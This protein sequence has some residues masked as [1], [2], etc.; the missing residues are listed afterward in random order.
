VN[1]QVF[2]AA[3]GD[4]TITAERVAEADF[5]MP[6]TQSGLSWLVLSE[7]S[8]QIQ[9]ISLNPLTMEL[10]V[11][12]V[13]GFFFTGFVVWMIEHPRKPEYQGSGLRQLSSALYFAFLTMTFSHGQPLRAQTSLTIVGSL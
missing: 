7:D 8:K 10:W 9:W 3:V 11:A 6:Y 4:V 5:T 13:G 12:T 1:K 2:D